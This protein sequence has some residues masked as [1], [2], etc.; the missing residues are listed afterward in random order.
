MRLIEQAIDQ[1]THLISV[2]GELEGRGGNRLVGRIDAMDVAC[3]DHVVLDLTDMSFMDSTGLSN[4]LSAWLAVTRGYGRFTL[5][6]PEDGRSRRIFE[7]TGLLKYLTLA[8]T[9]EQALA[10]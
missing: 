1:Q 4:V 8:G 2:V 6:V 3:D 5:V 9:R 7:I 10:G